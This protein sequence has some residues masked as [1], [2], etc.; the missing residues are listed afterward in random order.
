MKLL[1]A[2]F[3]TLTSVSSKPVTVS[4]NDETQGSLTIYNDDPD[5]PEVVIPLSVEYGDLLFVN[6]QIT[7][8]TQDSGASSGT[9][10]VDINGDGLQDVLISNSF[11]NKSSI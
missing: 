9:A 6:D 2:P 8:M 11:F 1:I 10:I 3:P 4:S 7:P 5:Q